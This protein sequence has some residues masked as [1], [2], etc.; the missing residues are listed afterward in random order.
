M[1]KDIRKPFRYPKI[2][3]KSNEGGRKRA[4]AKDT[5]GTL[6]RIWSYVAEK[7]GLLTLVIIMVVISAIFGLLGPFV[8]GK[9]IDHFI[10]GQTTDGLAGVLFMLF[11]I[12]LV[13]SLSLWFQNYWMINISQST[14]FKMRSE[15]FTHLHELPIPFFDKQRLG[16]LMSRVTN[17]IENVSSTLNT[18][19]IQVLSS[20]I[21]FVGT[22][23]VMLY[24]SPLLT[25]ITLLIIPIMLLS[26]K[27]ITNRTG[28]LFKQQ[29][30]NLGEL[31]G[32]IEESISG[33]KVIKAYSREDR[34][35]EQFLEKNAA[36]QSSGFWAQTIS[37]FIPK[38]MNSLNNL[39]FT[40][41]AAVGGLFAL[42]G[43]ISI[44]AIVVFAEYSRQFTRP[45]NDL[46]N[47]FNTMLSAI[48]GAERVFDVLDEK[49]EREDE[50]HALY[51]PIK[52]GEIEFRDV[53]FGYQE[54][55]LILKQLSFS[56]PKGQSIA[57]VGPTGAGKTTVTSLIARFYEPNNGKILIDG[58]DI[59]KLTRSSLRKNMGFVLQDSFLFQG[60]I[61]ENIRYGRL[62]ASD[63]EVE[64][65]AKA[66]NAHGFIER[67]PKGYDTVLIQNG[68]GIS[69][70]QKQLISIARAVLAD[71]VLLIL[72]EATSNIDTVTE[73]KIQEALGRLMAG[74]TSVIIAHRLN[75]IQ[76][77]DQILVLK[78]GEMA[79][80]GTHA[81]LLSQ[82]GFYQELYE[83][84]FRE[85]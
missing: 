29:Q 53:S 35:M 61:R 47:Q 20:V 52:T 13:Q 50:E 22:I 58:T 12:Y 78:D 44:G 66:A 45:L 46:A 38:V 73:V 64:A 14:V 42:K 3:L 79:E 71:P 41:I 83:S 85:S 72:D 77:A 49:E 7:K 63:Q 81:E 17:D 36:L 25:L 11:V 27:W 23:A 62:D 84:Q 69:Q 51:Q 60:T 54:D 33:A 67:L 16:D 18:S 5:K 80:K 40:I 10:V 15:L 65:A 43:W 21:T 56:V 8:I 2:P 28:L 48:A 39:S 9:S 37:G 70:G 68:A 57:F 26:I 75:T 76:K 59:K 30:K 82:N 32:F 34:V 4:K 24:M 31:N 1:Q 55:S 6:R 19:V 74:R